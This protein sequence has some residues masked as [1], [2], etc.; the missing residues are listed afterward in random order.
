MGHHR[1]VL[2]FSIATGDKLHMAL[3]VPARLLV[4][5][6][7]RAIGTH[8]ILAVEIPSLDETRS[9]RDGFAPRASKWSKPTLILPVVI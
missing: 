2:N 8:G 9:L 5:C 6:Q 1:L 7:E 4:S 3:H